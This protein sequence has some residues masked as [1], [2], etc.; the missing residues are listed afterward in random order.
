MK[1]GPGKNKQDHAAKMNKGGMVK[2]RK[3]YN[4]GGMVTNRTGYNH[5]GL[6]KRA[7]LK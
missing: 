3:G 6:V 1:G 5:G 4:L 7:G 2:K